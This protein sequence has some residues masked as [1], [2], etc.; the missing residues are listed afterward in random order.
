MRE[1]GIGEI[2]GRDGLTGGKEDR[3]GG[4]IC[5]E[6]RVKEKERSGHQKGGET[7]GL[8]S[9]GADW[10][11]KV[12][13]RGRGVKPNNSSQDAYLTAMVV[14]RTP[15]A[16]RN[17]DK[18]QDP[19]QNH[20]RN[21]DNP[22]VLSQSSS[23]ASSNRMS[24]S[25]DTEVPL[26]PTLPER[27]NPD[28]SEEE[29]EGDPTPCISGISRQACC[30]GC[31]DKG[32]LV[33]TKSGVQEADPGRERGDTK[34]EQDG[35][36]SVIQGT[37]VAIQTTLK[38]EA[39]AGLT[40]DAVKYTLVVDENAQLE[41]VSLKDCFHSYNDNS[42][43]ETVYQSANEEEDPEYEQERKTREEQR[44]QERQNEEAK[45]RKQEEEE[46]EEMK[47]SKQSKSIST[48]ASEEEESNQVRAGAPRTKKFLN[49][50]VSGSSSYSA[51]GAGSF[52]VFSCV[53]N[54]VERQ[55]SHRA[56][57]RFV[58]RHG[59]EL[60]LETDDPVLMMKQSEDLWC[61]GYNMRTGATGIFP[62]YYTVRVAKDINKGWSRPG[63]REAVNR[64]EDRENRARRN[65][66]KVVNFPERVEDNNPRKFFETW[67]PKAL[68]LAAKNDQL[69]INRCRRS[70]AQL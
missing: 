31:H 67:L 55:Q 38:S 32:E 12:I 41:L 13:S 65:N 70:P 5:E 46:E 27:I 33:S 19:G 62:A 7:N 29:G 42:D 53:L 22:P 51:A 36:D 63:L 34:T 68:N 10:K 4:R 17:Q 49:V 47:I 8:K 35:S 43:A 66:I 28:I 40:Y 50:F 59:D 30:L 2:R 52:G 6:S 37:S 54:G 58:P 1:R 11:G 39:T 3:R 24:L 9:R 21:Q 44:K 48:T 60:H 18:T 14:P 57:Y 45:R 16:P 61:L 15:L 20:D 25:S 69:K 23:E 64:L 26:H 56:V